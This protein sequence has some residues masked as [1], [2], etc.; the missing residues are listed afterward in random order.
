MNKDIKI[1]AL[2]FA[3]GS[4]FSYKDWKFSFG[5]IKLIPLDYSGHGKYFK[6]KLADD[7][8]ELVKDVVEKILTFDIQTEEFCIYGHSLGGIVAYH[9]ALILEEDYFLKPLCTMVGACYSPKDFANLG[10]Y[11]QI[12]DKLKN[13]LVL[14]GRVSKTLVYTKEFEHFFYPAIKND[15][16]LVSKYYFQSMKLL[17]SDIDIFCGLFDSDI[18]IEAMKKWCQYSNSKS[19]IHIIDGDHFFLESHSNDVCKIINSI[20]EQKIKLKRKK[21]D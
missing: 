19:R 10:D 5:N 15:F 7:F 12:D 21:V 2:P 1:F 11:T 6:G 8:E 16:K 20:I 3:G 9:T 4:S 18:D 14:Q 17:Q 13:N